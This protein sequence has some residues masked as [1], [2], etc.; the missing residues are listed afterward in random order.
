MSNSPFLRRRLYPCRARQSSRAEQRAAE[1][2]PAGGRVEVALI[3]RGLVGLHL[4]YHK[5]RAVAF[6]QHAATIG[7]FALAR[8]GAGA[9]DPGTRGNLFEIDTEAGV[10]L[11]V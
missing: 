2:H 9:L 11:L 3:G 1:P 7:E 6:A 4:Q 10:A 8:Y 5:G